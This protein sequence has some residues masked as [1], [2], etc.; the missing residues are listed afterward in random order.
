MVHRSGSMPETMTPRQRVAA[1]LNHQEPDCVPISL[2][3]SANHLLE[4]RYVLLRDHFGVQDA[5]RTLGLF[6]TPI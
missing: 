6:T 5:R 1:A 4:E 3:G 2:G